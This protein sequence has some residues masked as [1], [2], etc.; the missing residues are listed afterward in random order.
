MNG[1]EIMVCKMTLSRVVWACWKEKMWNDHC[2]SMAR[3]FCVCQTHWG[4]TEQLSEKSAQSITNTKHVS[5]KI[6]TNIS[7]HQK[8]SFKWI[9]THLLIYHSQ[10]TQSSRWQ[11][12]LTSHIEC[13]LS[14]SS[15]Y[16]R[17]KTC[18]VCTRSQTRH[19]RYLMTVRFKKK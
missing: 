1:C 3:V 4:R 15:G 13:N 14:A 18:C 5:L 11:V 16:E 10:R 19:L 12:S 2:T 7:V 9:K 8:N 17:G 6:W